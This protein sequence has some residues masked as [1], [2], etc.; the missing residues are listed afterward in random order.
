MLRE[1]K[2]ERERHR[3][4]HTGRQTEK[5]K[6][7][8][9]RKNFAFI[10]FLGKKNVPSKAAYRHRKKVV[11]AKRKNKSC[12]QVDRGI[13]PPSTPQPQPSHTSI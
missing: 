1:R 2:R 13:Q 9:K 4:T 7:D 3:Q 5:Q 11:N 12:R 10:H 6:T 8:R